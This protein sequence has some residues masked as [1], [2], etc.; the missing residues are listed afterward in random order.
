[1]NLIIRT[2]AARTGFEFLLQNHLDTVDPGPFHA[3]SK[4]G[5]NPFDAS[6]IENKIYGL[7]SADVKLDFL[8]KA[9]VL[10]E[11]KDHI[12]FKLPPVL[13][14][15]FG[16][17]MGMQGALKLIRKNKISPKYALIG[18]PTNLTI[19]N[20]AKGFA[21]VEIQIP[22]SDAEIEYRNE[23]NFRESTTTQSK[24]FQGVSAHSSTPHLGESA[25]TKMLQYIELLPDSVAIMEIDGGSNYNTVP[26]HAFIELDMT[27]LLNPV[28]AKITTIFN[29]IKKLESEFIKY[30]D[31]SFI[32]S[33][34][35]LN[36][37]LI[38]T[39]QD[40]ILISGSCRILPTIPQ[41]IF[42]KWMAFLK[43]SC[44]ENDCSFR[45]TDYKKPFQTSENSVFL[46]GALDILAE[47]NL[48]SNPI[49]LPST[50]ETSLFSRT[51]VECL[52]FGP[53][54]RDNNIH[55]PNEHV[56][57]EDLEKASLFYRKIIERF[58]L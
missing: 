35:T 49:S 8:I 50:N 39:F 17:E 9:R 37:G 11:F 52:C 25:I 28:N 27:P 6:I 20:A 42:E 32:P 29:A 45:L 15:T 58:C 38:R 47:L 34:P 43:T 21:S 46:K 56:S 2:S 54:L 1:M 26:S 40:H 24:I 30:T 7:G 12:D 48:K 5:L 57:I 22:F 33:S 36:I 51:G 53:G 19:A 23:H 41:E 13:A 18:E 3:W 4:T 44:Q 55:T 14:A 31:Y 10:A 16:E